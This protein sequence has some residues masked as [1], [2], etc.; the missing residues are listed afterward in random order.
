MDNG[1]KNICIF[2][3]VNLRTRKE[4]ILLLCFPSGTH[5]GNIIVYFFESK[6]EIADFV[7]NQIPFRRYSRISF[8]LDN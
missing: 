1:Y 7:C 4:C 6:D 8:Q 5:L 3:D 2:S